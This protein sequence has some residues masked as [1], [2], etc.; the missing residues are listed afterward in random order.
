MVTLEFAHAT[1]RWWTALRRVGTNQVAV[2]VFHGD[3]VEAEGE[4]ID[5][6]DEPL[7]EWVDTTGIELGEARQ[8]LTPKERVPELWIGGHTLNQDPPTDAE[9]YADVV[10][11]IVDKDLMTR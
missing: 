2:G 3:W 1:G 9:G 10:G 5:A 11:S 7:R 8:E 6:L 4:G